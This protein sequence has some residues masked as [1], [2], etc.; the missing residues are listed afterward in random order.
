MANQVNL[1]GKP[2]T[3][4]DGSSVSILYVDAKGVI[5][6]RIVTDVVFSVTKNGSMIMT[7]HDTLRGACRS[8]K[9]ESIME[10]AVLKMAA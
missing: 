4:W 3:S 5:T 2:T 8:F 10:F 1:L 7:G 9:V 6:D